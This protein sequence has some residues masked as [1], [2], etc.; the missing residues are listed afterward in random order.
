VNG[1]GK[2]DLLV[3]NRSNI[4]VGVLLGNGDG[5][6]AAM[7]TFTTGSGPYAVA[8]ADVNGDGKLDVAVAN[9][10][11]SSSSV[12]LGNGNGTFAAKQDEA[13]GQGATGLALADINGDGQPDLVATSYF[14]NQVTVLLGGLPGGGRPEFVAGRAFVT[15]TRPYWVAQADVNG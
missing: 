2:N 10:G 6:F 3:A 9:Y 11:S 8:V 1:D 7:Q 12:L 15:G 5:T 4:T 13:V 14:N